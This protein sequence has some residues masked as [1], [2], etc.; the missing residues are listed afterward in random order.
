[1]LNQNW[2]TVVDISGLL[3]RAGFEVIRTWHEVIWPFR[4]PVLEP[5]LNRFLVRFWPFHHLALTNFILARPQPQALPTETRPSVSVIIPARNEAGNI[6]ELLSRV[7]QLGSSTELVF[8]EGH[9]TDGTYQAIREAI[10][11]QAR[12]DCKLLRQSGIGKGDAVRMGM[13]NAR[14]DILMILD[15]DLTVPPEDLTRFYEVLTSGRGEFANGVRL[16]YPL[17]GQAMRFLNLVGNKCFG[18]V[19]SWILSQPVKDSLCG[20][21]ALWKSDY[22]AISANRGYFGD[23]DPFGDFDLLL[24]AAK[25]NRKIVDLPIRYR[26]R[27]YGETNIDRV[28][29]GLLLA[30][31][32]L[33]AALRLKFV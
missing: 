26:K 17:E 20:T 18:A 24:G 14:G 4:T 7:P 5:L 12:H 10:S 29:H 25:L 32:T 8:V 11:A 9:S 3:N 21:K 2:L 28:R 13:S 6:P 33:L 22:E 15:A 23:L 1:V 27:K 31:T 16:V 30:R 19:L